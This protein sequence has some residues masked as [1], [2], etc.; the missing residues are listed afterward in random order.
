MQGN[1]DMAT[2]NC[3]LVV[4]L[5]LA[6]LPAATYAISGTGASLTLSARLLSPVNGEKAYTPQVLQKSLLPSL[7]HLDSSLHAT[8]HANSVM[9]I[10]V[11][12]GAVLT[13]SCWSL[14]S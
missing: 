11:E 10:G 8:M 4:L 14:L 6:A 13:G 1:F 2:A 3:L 9:R 12:G 5:S 7:K